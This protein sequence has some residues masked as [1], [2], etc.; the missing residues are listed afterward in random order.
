MAFHNN[1]GMTDESGKAGRWVHQTIT[2]NHFGIQ[3]SIKENGTIVIRSS[4]QAVPDSD[5]VEYEEVTIP[6]SLVF[7]LAGYLKDTREF[8]IDS[9]KG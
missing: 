6:A 2:I 9:S 4:P 5:E 7:K 3:A 8:K 1:P